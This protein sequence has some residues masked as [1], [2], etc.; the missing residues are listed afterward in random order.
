MLF[1]KL[2]DLYAD[3]MKGDL[4]KNDC[5]NFSHASNIQIKPN[6]CWAPLHF[7]TAMNHLSAVEYLLLHGANIES[8]TNEGLTPLHVACLCNHLQIVK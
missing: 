1:N 3:V 6:N 5:I 7:E 4:Q 2:F 8:K